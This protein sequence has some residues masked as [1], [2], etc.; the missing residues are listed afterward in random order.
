MSGTKSP[1]G[2]AIYEKTHQKDLVVFEERPKRI[3]VCH[4]LQNLIREII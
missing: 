2:G 3:D 4:T 1:G